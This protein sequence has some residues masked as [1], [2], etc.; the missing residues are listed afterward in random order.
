MYLL[1]EDPANIPIARRQITRWVSGFGVWVQWTPS[2][3]ATL[4]SKNFKFWYTFNKV[5]I[6]EVSTWDP[7]RV[8]WFVQWT[9]SNPG[10]IRVLPL[11][12]PPSGWVKSG[13]SLFF[14]DAK[15]CPIMSYLCCVRLRNM[16]YTFNLVMFLVA[17]RLVYIKSRIARELWSSMLGFCIQMAM[18]FTGFVLNGN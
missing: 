11:I 5:A 7:V 2:N 6:G 9:P 10:L 8:S 13:V 4:N 14:K 1:K 17:T 3:P 15:K 16:R 18:K 12:Q